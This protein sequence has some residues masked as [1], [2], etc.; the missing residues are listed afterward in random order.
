MA[1][2]PL[3][4]RQRS[5]ASATVPDSAGDA[6]LRQLTAIIARLVCDS[7]PSSLPDWS[8]RTWCR[9]L[10]YPE[11]HTRAQAATKMLG[12]RRD[13]ALSNPAV[14]S[15][16]EWAGA[17]RWDNPAAGAAAALSAIQLA[18]THSDDQPP[19]LAELAELVAVRV[20]AAQPLRPCSS[21]RRLRLL[22]D[23]DRL[24]EAEQDSPA[25]EN[26]RLPA[27]VGELLHLAGAERDDAL[28]AA[29]EAA[30]VQAGDWWARHSTPAPACLGEPR[31]PGV[32]PAQRLRPPERLSA[33][34]SDATLLGLVAGP[35]PGRSRPGQ[36]AWR[37]GLTFWVA[38]RLSA[39]EGPQ[40]PPADTIQ[41]WRAQLAVLVAG[42]GQTIAYMGSRRI[43][44]GR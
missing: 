3:D 43:V 11:L 40:R 5:T 10:A 23:P 16:V 44:A 20:D 15:L 19:E 14:R 35:H 22:T 27:V 18:G 21:C 2:P 6:S 30:V 1:Q 39:I 38:A 32:L 36:V 29:V 28:A 8:Y 24:P 37:R 42:P 26:P 4:S 12:Q 41:W 9:A 31:L 17:R 13:Q 34:V 33:Y 25:V 7:C